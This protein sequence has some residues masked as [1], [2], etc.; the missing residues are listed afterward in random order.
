MA[1]LQENIETA[2]KAF[3]DATGY[4]V[5]FHR[6][7]KSES[8][9]MMRKGMCAALTALSSAAAP[10]ATDPRDA[11]IAAL[12]ADRD[13]ARDYIERL[14]TRIGHYEQALALTTQPSKTETPLCAAPKK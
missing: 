4:Y 2:C 8:A 3:A 11:E 1:T 5:P 13:A 12:I 14:K 10:E 6:G 9:D 7:L